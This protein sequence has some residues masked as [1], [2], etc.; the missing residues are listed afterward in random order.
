MHVLCVPT[1]LC[2]I[3]IVV[4]RMR[5]HFRNRVGLRVDFISLHR[6]VV[7]PIV[8]SVNYFILKYEFALTK[9]HLFHFQ[10]CILPNRFQ[11]SNW[12]IPHN[13]LSLD[14]QQRF[15]YSFRWQRGKAI[16]STCADFEFQY[17]DA[18]RNYSCI[19]M[20]I[21]HLKMVKMM[22]RDRE[23]RSTTKHETIN[24]NVN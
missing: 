13:T 4:L 2:C 18:E 19:L 12:N 14:Q 21:F 23:S 16:L 17:G 10:K 1:L 7:M 22:H 20:M 3:D 11:F 15:R 5:R 9:S 24:T 8:S 6:F